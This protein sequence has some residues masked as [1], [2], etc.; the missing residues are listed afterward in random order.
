VKIYGWR[1]S[2]DD[3]LMKRVPYLLMS[4]GDGRRYHD[5]T[6]AKDEYSNKKYM[7]N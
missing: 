7:W 5:V 6:K 2:R 3:Y 1:V 4:M